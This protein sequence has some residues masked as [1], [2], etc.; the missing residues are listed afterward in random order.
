MHDARELTQH[1]DAAVA[2]LARRGYKFDPAPVAALLAER[3]QAIRTGDE[4]RAESKRIA[5][6]VGA[7][8]R[9]GVDVTALK[10]SARELKDRIRLVEEEAERLA[11]ELHEQLL[12]IPN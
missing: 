4:L 5:A 12:V 3:N 9:S 11:A 2:R 6:E 1:G 8:A 10:E 7:A